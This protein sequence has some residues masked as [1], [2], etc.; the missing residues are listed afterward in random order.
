[1]VILPKTGSPPD[2]YLLWKSPKDAPFT[3]TIKNAMV[4]SGV[5]VW[6]KRSFMAIISRPKLMAKEAVIE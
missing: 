5:S 2:N 3:N 6:L 1:M 4:N